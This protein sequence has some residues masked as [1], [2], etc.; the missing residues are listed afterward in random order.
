MK[1]IQSSIDFLRIALQ[2]NTF[3][4][5]QIYEQRE[6]KQIEGSLSLNERLSLLAQR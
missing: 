3:Y 1:F 5:L 4:L 2:L 6:C